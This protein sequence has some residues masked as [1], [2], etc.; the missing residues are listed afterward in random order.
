MQ[1][2]DRLFKELQAEGLAKDDLIARKDM[3]LAT[4]LEVVAL[5]SCSQKSLFKKMCMQEGDRRFKE[6]QAEI[7][8]K[9]EQIAAK[10]GLIAS[11]DM[12]FATKETQLE[13]A[14]LISS[15]VNGKCGVQAL[16][17][18]QVLINNPLMPQSWLPGAFCSVYGQDM[19]FDHTSTNFNGVGTGGVEGAFKVGGPG[20]LNKFAYAK[21]CTT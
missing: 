20:P 15:S 1:E 10:D 13:V 8:A 17:G 2:R 16:F 5:I 12:E 3:E 19:C 6:L 14:A 4:Q 9:N 11:K 7:R 18:T 21:K